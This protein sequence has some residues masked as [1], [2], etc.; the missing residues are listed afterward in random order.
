MPNLTQTYFITDNK[1][2]PQ[3]NQRN[4]TRTQVTNDGYIM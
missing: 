3:R 4:V 2:I 1:Y